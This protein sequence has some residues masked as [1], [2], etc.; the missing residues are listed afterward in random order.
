MM[1]IQ[2]FER[3]HTPVSYYQRY[4]FK[5]GI[6]ISLRPVAGFTGKK[7]SKPQDEI[8]FLTIEVDFKKLNTV[9][10]LYN[11]F[12]NNLNKGN[13]ELR[14]PLNVQDKEGDYMKKISTYKMRGYLVSLW[15]KILHDTNKENIPEW[16]TECIDFADTSGFEKLKERLQKLQKAIANSNGEHYSFWYSLAFNHLPDFTAPD[17]P[18]KETLGSAMLMTNF[19]LK[20]QFFFWVQPWVNRV[21]RHIR[22]FETLEKAI[23]ATRQ[24]LMSVYAGDKKYLP[25]IVQGDRLVRADHAYKHDKE[26]IYYYQ[27]FFGKETEATIKELY[28]KAITLVNSITLIHL[29][30]LNYTSSI[31]SNL[32]AVIT[33]YRKEVD[34]ILPSKNF[35]FNALLENHTDSKTKILFKN[36]L[37]GRM[38]TLIFYCNY[39]YSIEQIH[40]ILTHKVKE[41]GKTHGNTKNC[42]SVCR[43]N[44]FIDELVS[45]NDDSAKEHSIEKVMQSV[46]P[47]EKE[48][49]EAS[50]KNFDRFLSSVSDID[51]TEKT[52]LKTQLTA[53]FR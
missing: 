17:E 10:K 32:E 5:N 38:A 43:A 25:N 37:L 51:A 22:D 29:I 24:Q 12:D 26:L 1:M 14:W 44:Y 21:Y 36:R 2:N 33:K 50:K 27:E 49:I 28:E 39:K 53:I 34:K 9:E 42:Y 48:L 7:N 52:T 47:H 41:I 46:S 18:V 35:G 8:T 3:W 20:P 11:H 45:N 30:Q 31:P 40:S 16:F 19:E 23:S 6:K 4:Q 15:Y 13:P